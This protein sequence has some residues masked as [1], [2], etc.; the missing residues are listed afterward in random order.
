MPYPAPSTKRVPITGSAQ[1]H[2][3]H[4]DNPAAPSEHSLRLIADMSAEERCALELALIKEAI[5]GGPCESFDFEAFLAA[6]T[7]KHG[8]A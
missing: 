2:R 6:M 8:A 1:S 5:D 3:P 4:I 7:V